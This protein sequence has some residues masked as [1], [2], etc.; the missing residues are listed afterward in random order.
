VRNG[1][2]SELDGISSQRFSRGDSCYVEGMPDVTH[3]LEEEEPSLFDES[4]PEWDAK[5]D[6]EADADI[7]AGRVVSNDAGVEWLKTWGTPDYRPMPR[8]WLE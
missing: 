5:R 1:G 3:T 7:A 2:V 8:E 4:D 6:A